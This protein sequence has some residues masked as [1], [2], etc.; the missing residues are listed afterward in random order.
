[1]NIR[2]SNY[3]ILNFNASDKIV[4]SIFSK[5]ATLLEKYRG[6]EKILRCT[7]W[8]LVKPLGLQNFFNKSRF[9]AK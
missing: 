1:M 4:K 9:A 7:P 5:F 8:L 2:L 3:Y 6:R